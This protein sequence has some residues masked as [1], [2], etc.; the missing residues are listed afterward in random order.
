[1]FLSRNFLRSFRVSTKATT[2]RLVR[3]LGLVGLISRCCI[4][5]GISRVAH[6]MR[7]VNRC[8]PSVVNKY[9]ESSDPVVRTL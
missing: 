6:V 3:F 1:M 2:F 9:Q 7:I 8:Q 5:F 4:E